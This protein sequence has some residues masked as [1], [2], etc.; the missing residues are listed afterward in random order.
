MRKSALVIAA[1]AGFALAPSVV[2]AQVTIGPELAF[3]DNNRNFGV[4]PAFTFSLPS[5]GEGFALFTD[6]LIFFPDGPADYIEANA[7][8]T[9]DFPLENS[10]AVPFVLGGL[11]LANSS[12]TVG[13]VS[14]SATDLG[15]N[16][17][18][19]INFDLGKFRPSAGARFQIEGG[20]GIVIFLTLPFVVGN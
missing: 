20:D 11:T 19:G 10:T 4:G 12:V 9:Y 17:G 15:I 13:T 8:V 3:A 2:Q 5:L 16:L 6:L 7:N 18:G 14:T 1:I